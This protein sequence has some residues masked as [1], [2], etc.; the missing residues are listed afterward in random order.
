[1]GTSI[2]YPTPWQETI[3]C[4]KFFSTT[5]PWIRPIILRLAP[6]ALCLPSCDPPGAQALAP[7]RHRAEPRM[8]MADRAGERVGGI[9]A[10]ISGQAQQPLHH[11]LHLLLARMALPHHRLLDLQRRV[12]GH[13]QLRDHGRAD[14]RTPSLA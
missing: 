11:L 2:S 1:M 7:R 14:R 6:R 3:T 10:G 8:G 9:A 12:F 13:G 5:V 4:G